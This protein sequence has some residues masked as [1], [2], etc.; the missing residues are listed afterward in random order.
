[1]GN[2]HRLALRLDFNSLLC[3]FSSGVVMCSD[4]G[5]LLHA[6]QR[7]GE[8]RQSPGCL[9]PLLFVG[10]AHQTFAH[11]MQQMYRHHAQALSVQ[12]T[13][14]NESCFPQ[15]DFD[16]QHV[17]FKCPA[18]HMCW[19]LFSVFMWM[20]FLLMSQVV[21]G[22]VVGRMPAS[23][24]VVFCFARHGCGVMLLWPA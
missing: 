22:V 16:T 10:C 15:F 6:V 5:L 3:C 11:S 21:S 7:V 13:G 19:S 20:L 24:V 8:A 23:Y 17:P 14:H 18:D 9:Q 1:M 12:H 2:A 4:A